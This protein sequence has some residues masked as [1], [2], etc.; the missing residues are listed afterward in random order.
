MSEKKILKS[1]Q[2]PGLEDTYV[3][4]SY[5]IEE[6]EFENSIILNDMTNQALAPYSTAAG[7]N[8]RA[9]VLGYQLKEVRNNDGVTAEIVVDDANLEDKARDVYATGDTLCFDGKNHFYTGLTINSL[10]STTIDGTLYSIIKID[11]SPLTVKPQTGI[12][13]DTNDDGTINM[14]EKENWVWVAEKSFGTPMLRSQGAYSNGVALSEEGEQIFAIGFGASTFGR[15]TKAIG[16]Y[17]HAEGRNTMANYAAHAEGLNTKALNQY[18]HAEGY[19]TQALAVASHAEGANTI[20]TGERAHAEGTSTKAIGNNS[21]A[22]GSYT[23]SEG[24]NS[25]AEGGPI[26]EN[27]PTAAK[28][29]FS[30]AEGHGSRANGTGSH[31]EGRNNT[32]EGNNSHAEGRDGTARGENSHTEGIAC[33]TGENARNSHAEG[34]ATKAFGKQ[35]HAEGWGTRANGDNQHVQGRWNI[36]DANNQYAHIVGNGDVDRT[37]PS[38]PITT[39]SNAHTIDWSGN[40]WFAGDVFVGADNDQLVSLKYIEELK[41]LI[42]NELAQKTQVQIITWEAD[43]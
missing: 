26:N 17:A 28:G 9:G 34:W 14:D 23:I 7:V 20:V 42:N 3:I 12:Q 38:N 13:V 24:I 22:E 35:S 11:I 37:D 8:T 10:S 40:A 15:N 1:L 16:D 36:V 43:D 5:P 18:A 2:F 32:A 6:G 33:E 21:H 41:T 25:H 4:P 39:R 29:D 27:T 19:N 30:H 31:A